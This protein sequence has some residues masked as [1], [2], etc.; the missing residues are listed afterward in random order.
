MFCYNF[1][2]IVDGVYN[3]NK[4]FTVHHIESPP[5]ESRS[6]TMYILNIFM[7]MVPMEAKFYLSWANYRVVYGER[8]IPSRPD[9]N[10]DL[11]LK[12]EQVRDDVNFV[13][14]SDVW[15][16][17]SRVRSTYFGC[18]NS[19][20]CTKISLCRYLVNCG[21]Y[22]KD[23]RNS[24]HLRLYCLEILFQTQVRQR[25]RTGTFTWVCYTVRSGLY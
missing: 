19:S 22:F 15:L 24:R 23:S 12:M 3:A 17:D 16:T 13:I 1:F 18:L 10:N 4:T 11:V 2:V 14:L 6:N 5:A 7:H 21:P 20:Q 9:V 8:L 25:A